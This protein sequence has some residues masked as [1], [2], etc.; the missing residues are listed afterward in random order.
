MFSTIDKKIN[1]KRTIFVDFDDTIFIHKAYNAEVFDES[2]ISRDS[3]FDVDHVYDERGDR[4]DLIYNLLKKQKEQYGDN[5]N[6][7]GLT[8]VF[9]S[10]VVNGKH[11]WVDKNEP[12][13]FTDMIGVSEK[14]GKIKIMNIYCKEKANGDKRS[15]CLIDDDL[16]TIKAARQAG[17]DAWQT[18]AAMQYE[19][20]VEKAKSGGAGH[21]D[22]AE[23]SC[24]DKSGGADS[25]GIKNEE[26]DITSEGIKSEENGI[27]NKVVYIVYEEIPDVL[28]SGSDFREYGTYNSFEEA[29]NKYTHSCA[30]TIHKRT[31]TYK[32]GK[33]DIKTEYWDNETKSFRQ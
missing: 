19:Y 17:Y 20:A 3:W 22:S 13:I 24:C 7:I 1:S 16:E 4:N 6:I 25:N 11:R 21:R 23:R 33:L 28:G 27:T 8:W 2:G 9:D 30:N 14:I 10:N 15:I 29:M 18:V 31:K 5:L 32:D 12:G 26:N